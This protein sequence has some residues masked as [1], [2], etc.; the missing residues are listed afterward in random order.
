MSKGFSSVVIEGILGRDPELRSTPG[1]ARVANF[2]IAVERGY[3]D[4]LHTN[5]FNIVAWKQDAEFAEKHLKKG[6]SVRVFG[7]LDTRSWDDKATGAKRTVTEVV[8]DKIQ[9]VDSP[10]TGPAGGT[11]PAPTPRA[12]VEPQARAS[13]PAGNDDPFSPEDDIPF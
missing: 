3:K 2:S 8:A 1:G 12:T 5:W 10:G 11:R 9:F 7:E 13:V 4:N 6:K